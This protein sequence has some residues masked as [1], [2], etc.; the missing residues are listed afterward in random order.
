M[1]LEHKL[2]LHR[3]VTLLDI[4]DTDKEDLRERI[5]LIFAIEYNKEG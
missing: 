2:L 5:D 4:S 1:I 3:I